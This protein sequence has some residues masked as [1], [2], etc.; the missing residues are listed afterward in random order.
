MIKRDEGKINVLVFPIGSPT[1]NKEKPATEQI[2]FFFFNF[3]ICFDNVHSGI[4]T[5]SHLY[6]KPIQQTTQARTITPR[7]VAA[8]PAGEPT[9][10]EIE[11]HYYCERMV[12]R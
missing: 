11:A 8:V 5:T 9:E 4:E 10:A 12:N 2:N 6:I 3:R 7:T 1:W